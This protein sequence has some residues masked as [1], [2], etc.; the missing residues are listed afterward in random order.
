MNIGLLTGQRREDV[1]RM[2]FS[3][4]KDG[5]LFVTQSKTGHKLAMPLDLELKE[6]GMSLE[7][8]V[9]ECRKITHRIV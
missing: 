5:R 1:T 6:L 4:I 2:K 7:L 8:I 3:A 9:D